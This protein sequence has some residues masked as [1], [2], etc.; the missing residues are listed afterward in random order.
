MLECA[1]LCFS[2]STLLT[3]SAPTFWIVSPSF[4]SRDAIVVRGVFVE[5]TGEEICAVGGLTY[6]KWSLLT[7]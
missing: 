7:I 5:Q 4:L 6:L 1:W 3:S 2:S